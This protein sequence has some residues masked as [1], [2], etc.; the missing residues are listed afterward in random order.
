MDRSMVR[1]KTAIGQTRFDHRIHFVLQPH[2]QPGGLMNGTYFLADAAAMSCRPVDGRFKINDP[3][4]PSDGCISDGSPMMAYLVFP[5]KIVDAA[6][7]NLPCWQAFLIKRKSQ[8]L[9]FSNPPPCQ[10]RKRGNKRNPFM[11]QAPRA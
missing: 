7:K 1:G 9:V 2:H 11:S 6:A 10:V 4:R 3:Q 8:E 5:H